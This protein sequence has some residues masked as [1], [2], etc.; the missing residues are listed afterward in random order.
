MHSIIEIHNGSC[1]SEN[2]RLRNEAI[3]PVLLRN[4]FSKLAG[5]ELGLNDWVCAC[6]SLKK[7]NEMFTVKVR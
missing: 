1:R 4:K 5:G 7:K 6:V 3:K 2:I